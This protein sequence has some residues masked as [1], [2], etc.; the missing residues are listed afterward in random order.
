MSLVTVDENTITENHQV[1]TPISDKEKLELLDKIVK[2]DF[3]MNE[4]IDA[5]REYTK[6]EKGEID[7]LGGIIS[8]CCERVRTGFISETYECAVTYE[9]THI[10]FTN[11][12][13]GE[14]V[15]QREMTEEEQLRLTSNRV[16]AEQVIRQARRKADKEDKG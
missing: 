11:V 1:K 9:G 14:I 3:E 6:A 8:D 12:K 16:D 13:N 2:T 4:K 15:E 7:A 5:L 10:T